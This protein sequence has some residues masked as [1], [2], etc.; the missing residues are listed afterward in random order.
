MKI[1]DRIKEYCLIAMDNITGLEDDINSIALEDS[2]KIIAGSKKS[3]MIVTFKS[4]L[5]VN[6]IKDVLNI[7]GKRS[8]F[9]MEMNPQSFAA[10]ID[11]E[12]V[13]QFMFSEFNKKQEFWLKIEK[14]FMEFVESGMTQ[15]YT[16]DDDVPYNEEQLIGLSDEQKSSLMDRLLNDVDSLTDNQKKVLNFLASL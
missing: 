2:P 15:N 7:G 16:N 12:I 4:D 8:F 10:H 14:R 3:A 6:R 1:N 13:N 9:V 5:K 11:E